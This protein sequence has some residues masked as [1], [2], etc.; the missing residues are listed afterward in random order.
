MKRMEHLT[1]F[2]AGN[3]ALGVA[4]GA[5]EGAK[6]AQYLAVARNLTKAC[7][8]MYNKMPTGECTRST[9]ST[10]VLVCETL[11]HLTARGK[12]CGEAPE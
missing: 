12:M 6:G 3:L 7:F 5:V 4:N 10:A 8:E 9:P 2:V 11:S 1:C